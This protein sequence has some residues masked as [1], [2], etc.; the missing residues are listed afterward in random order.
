MHKNFEINRTKIKCGCQS[1]I[2]VVTDNSKSDR[3][4]KWTSFALAIFM[5]RFW[6]FRTVIHRPTYLPYEIFVKSTC[7]ETSTLH[8]QIG[9]KTILPKSTKYLLHNNRF[10]NWSSCTNT[11]AFKVVVKNMIALL[12]D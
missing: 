1:G 4:Q 6:G 9:D 8:F 2:K 11:L 5:C 3:W 10:V 12:R 7:C